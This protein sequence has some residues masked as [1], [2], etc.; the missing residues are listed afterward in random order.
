MN[1]I[2]IM[3]I[4]IAGIVI[5]SGLETAVIIADKL[6]IELDRKHKVLGSEIT[7]LFINHSSTFILSM[8]AWKTITAAVFITSFHIVYGSAFIHAFTRIPGILIEI[9]ICAFVIFFIIEFLSKALFMPN[10]NFLLRLFSIPALFFFLV[11]YPFGTFFIFISESLVGVN[12]DEK[13]K[14]D[15]E[16]SI[17]TGTD[18]LKPG[19]MIEQVT[20]GLETDQQN[21]A[22]FRNALEFSNVKLREIMVPRTEI[23]AVPVNGSVVQLREKFVSTRF[24]R[25]LAYKDS[26]DNIT[27]YFEVKDIFRNPEDLKSILRKLSIVPET[28]TASRLLRNFVNEKRNIALVVDEFG[29]TS[30]MV[31]IEDLLEQIVGDIEDEHDTSDLIEREVNKGEFIFSGRLEIDYLNETYNLNLPESQDYET[32]AGMVLFYHG[33]LPQLNDIIKIDKLTIRILRTTSTR[34]DLVNLKRE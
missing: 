3:L 14:I 26:I 18:L 12:Q 13:D 15:S 21:I 7:R 17:F 11:F 19:K 27:G 32:L 6:R 10:P 24:S 1:G 5:F 29:G 2:M 23:E 34:I 22:I 33:S 9:I 4:S 20:E 31:T 8:H 28:M 25:I 16:E 30:G